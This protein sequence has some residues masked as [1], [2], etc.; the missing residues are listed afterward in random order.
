MAHGALEE[1]LEQELQEVLQNGGEDSCAISIDGSSQQER[2]QEMFTAAPST[3]AESTHCASDFMVN[4]AVDSRDSVSDQTGPEDIEMKES[5]SPSQKVHEL[6]GDIEA[7]SKTAKDTECKC[8]DE[9]VMVPPPVVVDEK[10]QESRKSP[11]VV[12]KKLVVKLT[13]MPLSL[14]LQR[15]EDRE[16]KHGDVDKEAEEDPTA[17]S[18]GDSEET[19]TL[20]DDQENRRSPRVKTTPLRRQADCKSKLNRLD[21][22]ESD[23]ENYSSGK[24]KISK[25]V[26]EGEPETETGVVHSRI[27]DSDSDEVPAIL[28][29]T[30]AMTPSSGEYDSGAEDTS[31]SVKK[32]CLFGLKRN[33]SQSA[34]K[35]AIAQ[36][37]TS[38]SSE[39]GCKKVLTRRSTRKRERNGSETSSDDS[40][41]E[42][43]ITNLRKV[44]GAKRGSLRPKKLKH[45]EN[46]ES[47]SAKDE[48]KQI[49][50]NKVIKDNRTLRAKPITRLLN[51][52]RTEEQ[53]SSSSFSEEGQDGDSG[54]DS[55]VQK[56]RPITEMT[57]L[58]AGAFQ[59]SSGEED[60]RKP[61]SPTP[62]DDDDP[63]NRIAKKMLLAQIKANYSSGEISSTD[64]EESQSED[65]K[66]MKR[67]KRNKSKE[68]D[69]EEVSDSESNSDTGRKKT[70]YKHRL[71]HYTLSQSDRVSEGKKTPRGKRVQ[72]KPKSTVRSDDP[73][74]SASEESGLSEVLSS[75]EEEEKTCTSSSPKTPNENEKTSRKQRQK[76][77]KQDSRSAVEGS[78]G[79]KGEDE[80]DAE[81][82]LTGTPKG[83][84]KIRKIIDDNS[85]RLETQN[86][87]K[88]EE[89]RRK[90]ITEKEQLRESL[91][92][93]IVVED[94][95]PVSC[96]ITTKLVLEENEET[97]EPLVQVH[98]DLVTKL[99]P[100]QVDGV[101][102]M[103]DCCCESVK[104]AE[105]SPGSGCILAHCMGLGKSLQVVTFL[106]T[107]LQ[108]K[109]L[110]FRNA[111]IVCPLNTV[112]N[113]LNEFKKWQRGMKENEI[114]KVSVLG[115]AKQTEKR[116]HVLERWHTR[117]GV[118]ITGYEM[119]RTL[120]Q[121]R[122]IKDQRVKD[123]FQKTLVEPGPDF[124]ICDEGHILKNEASAVSKAL[125]S[126]K[127]RRR[128]VLTGT[129]LQNNLN[130]YHCMVNFIKENLLGSIKEFRNRFMNP[131][132]NGQCADSTPADVRLMKKRAHILYEM[133]AG[134][135]QR[136][137]YSALTK[138]LPPKYEYVLTVRMT[139]IQVKLY[140][141]YLE[142]II[143]EG[144]SAGGV[145]GRSGT[146]LFQDFQVLSRIWTHPW[147]LQLAY[148]KKESKGYFDE[149]LEVEE[150]VTRL[151][152]ENEEEEKG[153]EGMNTSLK[154]TLD[155]PVSDVR[156][157]SSSGPGSIP[158]DWY[159]EFV[160]EADALVLQH[161]GKMVILFEILHRAEQVGDKVLVFSQ[162][163]ISLDLIENFLEMSNR[164]RTAGQPSPYKG[165]GKW[166][167]NLDYYRLDGSTSAIFRKKWA[168]AFNNTARVRDRLFLIS[169][170]AGS[171]GINLV[172][173]NRVVIFDASWNPSY[174]IQSIF[175]VYRFGQQKMV[176][177][178]RFLAQGTMEE[179]IYD[180]QVTK[181]SLSFRVVDQQQIQRHFTTNELTELYSFEPDQLDDPTSEKKHKR[182]TTPMLPKDPVL[183]ELLHSFKDQIV[184]YHEHDSLLDHKEEEALSEEER[185]A[186]WD[187]YE[188]EKKGLTFSVT[189]PLQS[190]VSSETTSSHVI[191]LSKLTTQELQNLISQERERLLMTTKQLRALPLLSLEEHIMQV[192]KD[193][194]TM[195]E[196]E[197]YTMARDR[198]TSTENERRRWQAIFREQYSNHQA[199]VTYAQNLQSD[200]N[201]GVQQKAKQ[202]WVMTQ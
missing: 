202:A 169:T 12:T 56:I 30:A 104:K 32:K 106:H 81:D 52:N 118:L 111:L 89:E 4:A 124:V 132:C 14:G 191:V 86:A 57:V 147:C 16:K 138:F 48:E 36:R 26:D 113:W 60:E 100:H 20:D 190:A 8:L 46:K 134:C 23:T 149:I 133:L 63:E 59:Q 31:Q 141:Q 148:D 108:R 76:V 18:T 173:A 66:K 44:T 6:A 122:N 155:N 77:N 115:T 140:R 74:T 153:G 110:K 17:L 185:K 201:A 13:P 139:P 33:V 130:E 90:R 25:S 158:P 197:V 28:L 184:G 58:G 198:K 156:V 70:Q 79:E 24:D 5:P 150:S 49:R 50:T 95:S 7:K 40:D 11:I 101:Q 142:H 9:M 193:N 146:R 180:R 68:E 120:T 47:E 51:S 82:D 188:A 117:G 37:I 92:E 29:Q 84:R 91:R 135:V 55:D 121:G 136:K 175:R 161:S 3:H 15:R 75:S 72:A 145:R 164:T 143:G 107:M 21:T 131:I 168:E 85:L 93:V 97:K 144:D 96:P 194:P 112:F 109:E 102:F 35:V 165:Q 178:Y 162:S 160:T 94:T 114:L 53:S 116:L 174:D 137:D 88:E 163:L 157:A 181:Q 62:D 38:R 179:K 186:A 170:R 19:V 172:A 189:Q 61:G 129:P 69:E 127:T 166:V 83:R 34:E 159:K 199:L 65:E 1:A 152:S 103:W 182:A 10:F 128:V 45:S 123:S 73:I 2:D 176:F 105:T 126:I 64:E 41:L 87:L 183:A 167:R 39:R 27:V 67:G 177:V 22:I 151:N 119:Y 78:S 43:E 192:G 195:S 98:R 171:L 200:A 196:V 187:E 154:G 54:D 99:K 71:L 42:K 80:D 125:S